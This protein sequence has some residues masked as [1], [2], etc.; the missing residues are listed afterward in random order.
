MRKILSLPLVLSHTFFTA[1]ML[2][3][4]NQLIFNINYFLYFNLYCC[5]IIFKIQLFILV[6]VLY[7][8]HCK[9]FLSSAFRRFFRIWWIIFF[10]LSLSVSL[11]SFLSCVSVFLIRALEDFRSTLSLL[12]FL[13][14]RARLFFQ[15]KFPTS[16]PFLVTFTRTN[17]DSASIFAERTQFLTIKDFCLMSWQIF[18]V[19]STISRIILKFIMLRSRE[20]KRRMGGERKFNFLLSFDILSECHL[21]LHYIVRCY[22]IECRV[23]MN[24]MTLTNTAY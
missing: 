3:N 24:A 5:I 18:A 15:A 8:L 17:V 6:Y 21:T 23:T 2:L 20:R 14:A 12:L 1:I 13:V 11:A 10:L 9:F 16:F 19:W 7:L 4:H 22:D